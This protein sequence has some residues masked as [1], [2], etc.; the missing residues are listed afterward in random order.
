MVNFYHDKEQTKVSNTTLSVIT[1]TIAVY[2]VKR[3]NE[4]R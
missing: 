2:V 4:L 1:V 3:K